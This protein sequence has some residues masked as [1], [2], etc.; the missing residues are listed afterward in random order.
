MF[1]EQI[2]LFC[3]HSIIENNF[4]QCHR[5]KPRI[6]IVRSLTRVIIVNGIVALKR[7]NNAL[8]KF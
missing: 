1:S 5:K 2:T 3:I 8:Y 4:Y 7:F 6:K